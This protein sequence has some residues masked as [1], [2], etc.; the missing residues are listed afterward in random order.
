MG[1]LGR[2]DGRIASKGRVRVLPRAGDDYCVGLYHGRGV[3]L[4]SRMMRGG[5]H[6]VARVDVGLRSVVNDGKEAAT[7]GGRKE[8]PG[9]RGIKMP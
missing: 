7:V 8:V 3:A 6:S 1:G 2:G 5:E 9:Q 4:G